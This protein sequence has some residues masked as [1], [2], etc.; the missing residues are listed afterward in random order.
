MRLTREVPPASGVPSIELVLPSISLRQG[1]NA[2]SLR[3]V[4]FAADALE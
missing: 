3:R 4:T 1:V 2:V